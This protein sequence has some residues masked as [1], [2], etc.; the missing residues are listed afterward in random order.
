MLKK[1]IKMGVVMS[2]L[3]TSVSAFAQ[4][5]G[6]AEYPRYSFWSNWSIG[7]SFDVTWENAQ[8][9]GAQ[10]RKSIN[11][12]MDLFLQHKQNHAI[13]T[14]YR[15]SFP[16]FWK[17]MTDN[18]GYDMA[19]Y[20][21]FTANAMWSITN[22][23]RGYDPDR[24]H[25]WYLLAGAGFHWNSMFDSD[26]MANTHYADGKG[27]VRPLLT[28]GI[29][30]SLRFTDHSSFFIEG[31]TQITDVPNLFKQNF[32]DLA[33]VN[34]E[35]RLGYMY[36]FGVT[37][38]DQ[39]IAAQKSMVTQENFGALNSQ[40]AALEQ[41]VADGKNNEKKLQRRINDLFDRQNQIQQLVIAQLSDRLVEYQPLLQRAFDSMAYTDFLFAKATQAVEWQL[42]HPQIVARDSKHTAQTFT[43]M[44]NP[45]LRH[46]NEELG[47]RYQPIDIAFGSGTCLITGANMAGKT[48]LLKTVGIMQLMA[49]F[50]FFVPAQQ[51]SLVL[52]DDVIF[53]IGDEQNEMNGL[54]SFASEII[55][56]SNALSRAERENLLILIDEPARTTN[57]IEGKAIVQSVADILDQR[58]SMSLI[59]THYS[60]LGLACRRLR[61]KGFV[62][63]SATEKLTP[64]N[65]NRFID[66]SLLAD[67][68]DDVPQEALRIAT[69]LQCNPL[70]LQRVKAF[71]C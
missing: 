4:N 50:G 2:L 28:A 26:V 51:A 66:Y 5:S 21:T 44:W 9:S 64:E 35:A 32:S 47:L 56:I 31:G 10:W 67:D 24:R 52:V 59:T 29:G 33:G 63:S 16:T 40:V 41:Q 20:I 6:K 57:P 30:Y 1:L 49:Q 42:V 62:E 46:R 65:I 58:P 54:S 38:A 22:G 8:V 17:G 68:S 25:S 45:R 61:V 27:H 37:A 39:A 55:K 19:R 69:I 60:Q 18:N 48:V 14:R 71:L 12:G 43:K 3:V 11:G 34:M 70:L 23:L 7:T 36:C 53:C 15:I 13:D